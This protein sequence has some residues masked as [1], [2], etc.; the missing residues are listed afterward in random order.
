MIESL[1]TT[2]L[3]S[4][5]LWLPLLSGLL[6]LIVPLKGERGVVAARAF[7]VVSAALTLVLTFAALERYDIADP[8]I[9]LVEKIGWI[10]SLGI[11]YSLGIDGVSGLIVTLTALLT[12]A[13]I[14]STSTVKTHVPLYIGAVLIMEGAVIGALV[15]TDAFL[16]Y[17]FWELML[18][19]AY[20]LVGFWGGKN[21]MSA[22]ITFVLYT[23]VG[24]VL[25]F[26]ALL[27]VVW[28]HYEQH[29]VVTFMLEALTSATYLTLK[30]ERWLFLAFAVA[31]FI[32]IPVIPFHGWLSRTY[33]EAHPSTT[34]LLS[35]VLSKVGLYSVIRFAIPLFPRAAEEFSLIIG[36]LAVTGIVY[37]AL[38]AWA[39][40]EMRRVLAYASLSHLGFCV[41][42][43]AAFSTI[44]LT[45]AVFQM[46]SHGLASAGLFL[47]AGIIESRTSARSLDEFGGMTSE[48]PGLSFIFFLFVLAAVGLPLTSGFVGEFLILTGSFAHMPWLTFVAILGIVVGTVYML[49]LYRSLFFGE[50]SKR[51]KEKMVELTGQD[52][53]YLVPLI[54]LVIYLGVFPGRASSFIEPS[55]KRII[56]E[57]QLR[58]DTRTTLEQGQLDG[59]QPAR[60]Q[61]QEPL[62]T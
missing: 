49:A 36:V 62:A 21:R 1:F 56:D 47:L 33:A 52:L 38:A 17:V 58:R 6:L 16:Y 53:L 2:S 45:G 43:V 40:R 10:D 48:A 51:R 54:L 35:G 26:A 22:A 11:F 23:L 24:S 44:S 28:R 55:V 8:R 50:P 29:G 32:K 30:E 27:F 3:L 14:L 46:V 59:M 5:T 15:A 31:F 37:G 34:A 7:G 61:G 4:L 12:L 39:Q 20:F 57:V 19:P 13:A 42:G 41:L 60:T 18:I 9:Q 25:M